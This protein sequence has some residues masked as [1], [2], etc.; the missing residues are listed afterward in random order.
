[1]L[2]RSGEVVGGHALEIVGW[3]VDNGKKYWWIKNSWGEQWGLGGYFRMIR[4]TN[5][6]HIEENVM[7]GVPDFFYPEGDTQKI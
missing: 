5:N 6:C 7:A 4:G 3:G 1:M 2:F